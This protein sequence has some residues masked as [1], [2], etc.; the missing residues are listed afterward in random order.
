MTKEE[1]QETRLKFY[2]IS[3]VSKHISAHGIPKTDGAFRDM[4]ASGSTQ[5]LDSE[6]GLA[7]LKCLNLVLFANHPQQINIMDQSSGKTIASI[8][9]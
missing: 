9:R 1:D 8:A 2:N 3:A 7:L 5:K 6:K 4:V